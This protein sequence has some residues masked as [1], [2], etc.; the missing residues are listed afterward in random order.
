MTPE[1]FTRQFGDGQRGFSIVT[2]VF[3]MMALSSVG[4]A[5]ANM[6]STLSL[7]SV[8]H[9]QADQAFYVAE[10]G[11]QY[12]LA[13]DFLNDTDF[14][15]NVSPTP[16][17]LNNGS[18]IFGDGEFWVEY[19]S[20]QSD[21][22]VVTVTAKVGDSLRKLQQTVTNQSSAFAYTIGSIGNISMQGGVGTINGDISATGNISNRANWVINGDAIPDNSSLTSLALDI[23]DYIALT[24]TTHSGNLDIAGNYST[25][26]YVDGNI[27]IEEDAVIS[28]NIIVASGN[29]SIADDV[30]LSNG[31]LAASGNIEANNVAN[32]I[33]TGPSNG[34]QPVL[35]STG[36]IHITA[37]DGPIVITG[38]M[39]AQGNIHFTTQKDSSL[40]FDG[41]MR[42]NGNAQ[43][44]NQGTSV[45][46]YDP[47]VDSSQ[48]ANLQ[49][50]GWQ[51]S[52]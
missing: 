9:F 48:G 33:L 12:A 42:M 45:L 2:V 28:S 18:I 1:K 16:P 19:S 39:L 6:L 43:L 27:D 10:A 29:I 30:T 24:D 49:L 14:S 52:E 31:T 13:A 15:D 3:V 50:S 35:V 34:S 17:P 8:V 44:S 21:S 20:L 37:K 47:D 46:S 26:V 32:V 51:E 5:L 11:L 41:Y 4:L 25:N 7:S 38:Y 40:T 22:A 36:N 23:D